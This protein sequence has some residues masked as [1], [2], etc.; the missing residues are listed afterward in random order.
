M[1]SECTEVLYATK[2]ESS[3]WLMSVFFGALAARG[4]LAPL[5]SSLDDETKEE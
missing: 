4:L 5:E 1:E 2:L 3:D